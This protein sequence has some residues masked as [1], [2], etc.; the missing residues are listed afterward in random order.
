MRLRAAVLPAWGAAAVLLT[1]CL[2]LSFHRA[3]SDE[4][5]VLLGELREYYDQVADAFLGAN[6]DAL[7][8]LYDSA[9]G[10]PMTRD[11]VLAWARDFFRKHGP[12][13]FKVDKLD[14]ER[15]GHV[16]AVVVLTYHVDTRD[17]RGSF[18]GVERDELVKHGRRWSIAAWEKLQ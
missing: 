4:E 5:Y 3:V 9:I 8:Q 17:G 13:H 16:S 12:A 15:V 6:A 18:H 7:A 14:V 2:S 1:G 11:Q 10:R